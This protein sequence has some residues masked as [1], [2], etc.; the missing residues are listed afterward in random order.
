M[1]DMQGK[2]ISA[3]RGPL[4]QDMEPAAA[5]AQRADQWWKSVVVRY[6]HSVVGR[7]RARERQEP[8]GPFAG[9]DEVNPEPVVPQAILVVSHGGLI[10]SL[11]QGLIGS[12]KV[13]WGDGMDADQ[14]LFQCANASVTVIEIDRSGKGT[15]VLFADTAHLDSELV[16]GNVDLVADS[17]DGGHSLAQ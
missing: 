7:S 8:N 16:D 2:T 14:S 6:V 11:L 13:K 9:E 15:L 4:P 12:R 5:V 17:C 10:R 3:W 1:G